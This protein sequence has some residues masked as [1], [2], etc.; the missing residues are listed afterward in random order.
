[1]RKY[2]VGVV[3]FLLM[4]VLCSCSG[5]NKTPNESQILSDYLAKSVDVEYA[6]KQ[7]GKNLSCGHN[8]D[9]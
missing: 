3:S 1:M 2:I 6:V 4:M 5:L 7:R 8:F 9:W